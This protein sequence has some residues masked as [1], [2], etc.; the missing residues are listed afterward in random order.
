MSDLLLLPTLD[1]LKPYDRKD[2]AG[3][4]PAFG[5]TLQVALA[6]DTVFDR[7]V[8][9][10]FLK[11]WEWD[12]APK[13]AL[14]FGFDE[15]GTLLTETGIEVDLEGPDEALMKVRPG[16]HGVWRRELSRYFDT[17]APGTAS[18]KV[19]GILTWSAGKAI[20]ITDREGREE[21]IRSWPA[22]LADLSVQ[23]WP[24]AQSLRLSYFFRTREP[25]PPAHAWAVAPILPAK[26]FD[27]ELPELHPVPCDL[28]AAP[29]GP[30]DLACF[31]YAKPS[32]SSPPPP[33]AGEAEGEAETEPTE[34]EGAAEPP[35]PAQA[36]ASDSPAVE[37]SDATPDTPADS[38][39]VRALTR[40][41]ELEHATPAAFF[42]MGSLWVKNPEPG[43]STWRDDWRSQLEDRL[44][45]GLRLGP[46]LVGVI[47]DFLKDNETDRKALLDRLPALARTGVAL[48][49]DCYG[50]GARPETPGGS[51]AARLHPKNEGLERR[52]ADHVYGSDRTSFAEY[53]VRPGPGGDWM[54]SKLGQ[55]ART[56]E[57][58]S[59][60]AAARILL[61]Q[62]ESLELEA[63]L[64]HLRSLEGALARE[65]VAEK[66]VRKLWADASGPAIPEA[67][68]LPFS[69]FRRQLG[70]DHLGLVWESVLRKIGP[71]ATSSPKKVQDDLER[72][73]AEWIGGEHRLGLVPAATVF[74]KARVRS[75]LERAVPEAP[76][77]NGKKSA[78]RDPRRTRG[79]TFQVDA[80]GRVP[81][82]QDGD[83]Q[84]LL[85]RIQGV[86]VMMK[87]VDPSGK[88]S[89]A[90][91]PLN[92]GKAVL[93]LDSKKGRPDEDLVIADQ[94]LLP[95]R[96]VYRDGLREVNISYDNAPIG[97]QSELTRAHGESLS[98]EGTIDDQPLPP[99]EVQYLAS[100]AC[101]IPSLAYGAEYQISP[102][103]VTT[104]GAA[105]PA[106]I[107]RGGEV[108]P[109]GPSC[110]VGDLSP[111]GANI[112]AVTYRRQQ[113]IG[114]LRPTNLYEQDVRRRRHF[115]LPAVPEGVE[116]RAREL[117]GRHE[118]TDDVP[119]VLLMADEHR[120]R[121][122]KV[123][124]SFS[125]G[126]RPPAVDLETWDRYL[127]LDLTDSRAVDRRQRVWESFYLGAAENRNRE[128][129]P[130]FFPYEL[131]LDD[132]AVTGIEVSL[133]RI[134]DDGTLHPLAE[135]RVDWPGDDGLEEPVRTDA[136]GPD[137]FREQ[138]PSVPLKVVIGAQEGL[139]RAGPERTPATSNPPGITASVKEGGLYRLTVHAVLHADAQDK[140][141]HQVE[142]NPLT[143]PWRLAIEVA[144]PFVLQKSQD[145]LRRRLWESLQPDRQKAELGRLRLVFAGL[146]PVADAGGG[147]EL[148]QRVARHVTR[149]ELRHQSW[150]WRG[151]PPMLS[152]K[153]HFH[154]DIGERFTPAGGKRTDP[155]TEEQ[156][157]YLTWEL[158][159]LG[160]RNDFE[161]RRI[162][163]RRS[164]DPASGSEFTLDETLESGGDVDLRA[165]HHRFGLEVRSRYAPVLLPELGS[166]EAR[167]VPLTNGLNDLRSHRPWRSLFV[168]CRFPVPPPDP[169]HP[170]R[171]P[172]SPEI[173]VPKVRAILPLTDRRE[174]QRSQDPNRKPQDPDRGAGGWLV[175]LDE[176]WFE[177][178]GLAEELHV[179]VMKV[180]SPNREWPSENPPDPGGCAESDPDCAYFQLGPDPIVTGKSIVE[181]IDGEATE[182]QALDQSVYDVR[183]DAVFGPAGHHR[184]FSDQSP[185][186]LASSFI[187]RPPAIVDKTGEDA[188]VE[189]FFWMYQ[190]RLRRQ[191]LV[192]AEGQCVHSE[193]TAPYWVQLVPPIERLDDHWLGD[194][195]DQQGTVRLQGGQIMLDT[196]GHGVE[197]RD[198]FELYAVFTREVVDV[199]GN[200]DQEVY[201]GVAG[202]IG[203]TTF[204]APK[205]VVE[206]EGALAE[207]LGV[208]SGTPPPMVGAV[209]EAGRLWMR[210]MEVQRH[211]GASI[212]TEAEPIWKMLFDPAVKDVDRGRIVRISS[213]LLVETPLTVGAG[214]P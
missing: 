142:P 132:P 201:V 12:S 38:F 160:D 205:K 173:P 42:D 18:S 155:A 25:V 208:R 5:L 52:L 29:A 92:I 137:F 152:E 209:S 204:P 76:G 172:V 183:F 178:G 143:S 167:D 115:D 169:R 190:I 60:N 39:L 105:P 100:D 27:A 148:R 13:Q 156:D 214:V 81:S 53:E 118:I 141:D 69:G 126:L 84:D 97:P 104:N 70:R 191:L 21:V 43:G 145:R 202:P 110:E 174:I 200:R 189:P 185:R 158:A 41:V 1:R 130:D 136:S 138:R 131:L 195:F 122:V 194:G 3:T 177:V 47:E 111:S 196:L 16:P 31:G 74:V 150:G 26:L 107:E 36:E 95:A 162:P 171:P 181:V 198:T 9:A 99:V 79:L 35:D 176:V 93:A 8:H 82:E 165:N 32:A 55:W 89:T 103:L 207:T 46:M 75:L 15:D 153:G 124:S 149:A 23:P 72:V 77:E 68:R 199:T 33:A 54:A 17:M 24:L 88:R 40:R 11:P 28:E 59:G 147:D 192:G 90:W 102:F 7:T 123:P 101:K 135:R 144:E 113:P 187:V 45:E 61:E 96:L 14:L 168:P 19:R 78:D 51:V 146:K 91:L 116:L 112:R 212:P 129:E 48:V 2:G 50:P 6:E 140:I 30:A 154:P 166:I 58:V 179:E 170:K 188:G 86:G 71:A 56:A 120:R 125:F 161:Y 106:V 128:D 49:A 80:L 94:I 121:D 4:R 164:F 65:G 73:L 175:V 206:T 151:R 117:G 159:H 127:A 57:E 157:R 98:G 193:P 83:A 67:G 134:D 22:Y 114:P 119:C 87:R 186:M 63:V 213:A 197:K 163:L 62:A 109:W 139:E 34:G 182:Y 108:L 184:D 210:L 180:I 85:E 37:T 10:T 64:G 203:G 20:E 211:Q 66:L 133:A 44:A